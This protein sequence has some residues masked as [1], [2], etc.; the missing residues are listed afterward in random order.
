MD[1]IVKVCKKHGDLT[2]DKTYYRKKRNVYECR[3]CMR[4]SEK[5]R[6]KREYADAFADYHRTYSRKWRQDNKDYVNESI[7]KDRKDNPEKY[8]ERE[9]N[10]YYKD[11]EKSRYMDVLKKHKISSD[12][13]RMMFE[14][15]NGLCAICNKKEVRIN[16]TRTG[17]TRLVIDHCHTTN[18][19]RGLL[20]HLCNT[21]IGK[22]KEDINILLAAIDYIKEHKHL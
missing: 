10:K 20:C 12:Q 15:Q 17:I 6:P 4:E 1:E 13:Y 14:D 2:V 18:K 3:Q 5:K 7:R 21:M 11:V 16:K 8:R 19:I 9:K 22:A